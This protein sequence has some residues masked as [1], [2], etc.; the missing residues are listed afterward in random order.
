MT[1]GAPGVPIDI[2]LL[3]H[4]AAQEVR[5]NYHNPSQV[6]AAWGVPLLMGDVPGFLVRWN[7]VFVCCFLKARGRI[8]SNR[9]SKR[10]TEN[11]Q[12][13]WWQVSL[14]LEVLGESVISCHCGCDSP[15]MLQKL[16]W[17]DNAVSAVIAFMQEEALLAL[18]GS[19]LFV[20]GMLFVG[21]WVPKSSHLIHM[22]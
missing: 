3:Y 2:L 11:K 18:L 12:C 22:I 14:Q 15:V 19:D 6:L 13:F 8:L 17:K 20:L 1:N 7:F 4:F 21:Q 9:F 16:S 10:I 5:L